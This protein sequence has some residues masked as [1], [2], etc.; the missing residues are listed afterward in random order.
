MGKYWTS[1]SD[2]DPEVVIR[3][4][5]DLAGVYLR[6]HLTPEGVQVTE[7]EAE[8]EEGHDFTRKLPEK[9]QHVHKS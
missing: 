8:M 3:A 7:P 5:G 1:I 6:Q 9:V 2:T 4:M